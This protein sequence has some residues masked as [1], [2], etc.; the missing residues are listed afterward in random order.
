MLLEEDGTGP[1]DVLLQSL[2]ML[3]QTHGRERRL[4]EFAAL[5]E[6]AGFARVAGKRTGAYLDAIIAYKGPPE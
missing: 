5:L 4:S 1:C 2:N 3:A 6:A